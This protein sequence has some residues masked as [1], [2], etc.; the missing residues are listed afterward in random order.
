MYFDK[1]PTQT[2]EAESSI[3]ADGNAACSRRGMTTLAA[4][5]S[6]H[7]H[8]IGDIMCGRNTFVCRH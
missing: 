1:M 7:V 2:D 8:C 6:D 3:Y 5:R 4:P